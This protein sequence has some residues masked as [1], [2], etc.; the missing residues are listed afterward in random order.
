[1]YLGQAFKSLFMFFLVQLLFFLNLFELLVSLLVVDQN[2]TLDRGKKQVRYAAAEKRRYDPGKRD[3]ADFRPFYQ[4]QAT[5][6]AAQY[7][8]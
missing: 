3:F 5:V 8:A 6:H 2:V 1:M 7:Q 4:R